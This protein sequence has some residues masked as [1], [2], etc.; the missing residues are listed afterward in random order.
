MIKQI[1]TLH[2]KIDIVLILG[3]DTSIT[4]LLHLRNL[5][6]QEMRTIDEIHALIDR[7]KDKI[8]ALDI[9]HIHTPETDHFRTILCRI[10]LLQEQDILDLLDLDHILE[11]KIKQ[12]PFNQ[13]QQFH[14]LTLKSTCTIQQRWLT[15]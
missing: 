12:I 2:Q 1:E 15:L 3:I 14:L 8:H 4:E 5:T 11:E 13:K 7:H 6:D 9:D 10:D